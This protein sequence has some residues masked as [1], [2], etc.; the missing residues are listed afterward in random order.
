MVQVLRLLR[1]L[2]VA[3]KIQDI[4]IFINRELLPFLQELRE[5]TAATFEQ[6]T[7]NTLLGRDTPGTG[8]VE[9][10]S[11]DD[12][13]E[14]TGSKVIQRAEITG[15]VEI[16][17]GSNVATV[18][19]LAG[20][21][22]D[23]ANLQ[24]VD[25]V[26]YNSSPSLGNERVLTSGTNSVVDISVVNQIKVNVDD[27]PLTGLADQAAE[28][29]NGNFT[30][31]AAPPTARA[32]T[33]VAGAGLTYTAGGTLAVGAGDGITVSADAVSIT[34]PAIQTQS[35]TGT[36]NAHVL[37]T[38]LNHGDTLIFAPTG[39][40][41]LNG[42]DLQD[43]LAVDWPEGFEFILHNSSASFDVT[44]IDEAGTASALDRIS[45]P[46]NQTII[47]G[48]SC[49]LIMRRFVTRWGAI[50][51]GWPAASTTLTYS[52]TQLQRAALTGFAAA[53]ANSN[54][55]T[56]AEPIVTYSSSGNMSAERVT[57]A[58][59]SVTINTS[60]ASQIA[61]ERAALTGAITATANS[62][63]TLFDASA[64]GAG[65]TGG[66]TAVLAV[67][68]G[69]SIT[70][71]ANDV[72][73]TGT[74]DEILLSTITGNQG[75]ID[76]STLD[77][78]GTVRVNSASSAYSIEGFTAKPVGFWFNFITQFEASDAC[79]LFHEDATATAVNRLQLP[80]EEDIICTPIAGQFVYCGESRWRYLGHNPQLF[81]TRVNG[82]EIVV[83]T[84]PVTIRST[85]HLDI[86]S[87]AS[88]DVNIDAGNSVNITAGGSGDVTLTSPDN[89]VVSSA[90][91]LVAADATF[92]NIAQFDDDT[93]F[94]GPVVFADTVFKT[95]VFATTL[96]A[97]TDNLNIGAVSIVR[98]GLTGSQTLTGMVPTSA[99][100]TVWMFNADSAD[101]L[102]L[103][104]LS[105][106]TASNQFLCP[107][108]VNYTLPPRCGVALWYDST[109][110]L[111]FILSK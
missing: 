78:G 22:T 21:A 72:S 96:A 106:S 12:T 59:T 100:Q 34:L 32:G 70:V 55:T 80:K 28:T 5:S 30:A 98:F 71:N 77:C 14:F 1:R 20:I 19:A 54:A 89:V 66:G 86:V 103:A 104:H 25:F 97:G 41:T 31:G 108:N 33:S 62:N 17:A 4:A 49:S 24:L 6:V 76:I 37:P 105:T 101:T 8:D 18:P 26:T 48:Q 93:T 43:A 75:T 13:L 68:A 81:G 61:F 42:I 58:S 7:T 102:T 39:A 99:G 88:D 64:S 109:S 92:N 83:S 36:L 73:Y 46:V 107:N 47:L 9:E 91:F 27:F 57:T 3:E 44:I 11:L 16:P 29:F 95:S 10:I 79:T 85:G 40:T 74:T 2:P 52:G 60:V 111:W 94:N 15:D 51:R 65:L 56:S 50:E 110:S 84:T 53:S 63:V 90:E 23:I 87:G 45:T 67:G 35:V 69:A 38:A 82:M